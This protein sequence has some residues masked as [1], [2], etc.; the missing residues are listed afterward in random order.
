MDK[1]VRYG[2]VTLWFIFGLL[3]GQWYMWL[4]AIPT[5]LVIA[6]EL[7]LEFS[8]KDD[9]RW[10]F[11]MNRGRLIKEYE[12]RFSKSIVVTIINIVYR[13]GSVLIFLYMLWFV[14]NPLFGI[15]Q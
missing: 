11:G 14:A 6:S 12:A 8:I 7:I 13:V 2:F 15:I 1:I 5:L 10:T 4:F 3:T 9:P